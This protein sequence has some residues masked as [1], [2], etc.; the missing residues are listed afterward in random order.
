MM[1]N[2][3]SFLSIAFAA[4][5]LTAC[6]PKKP[7]M[8]PFD[9]AS[10]VG[11]EMEA[12]RGRL[13][14][15]QELPGASEADGR[16]QWRKDGYVLRADYRKRNG[17]V[18]GFFLGFDDPQKSI[19][20]ENKNEL[21]EAGHLKETDTRYNVEWTEDPDRVERFKSVQITPAPRRHKVLVRLTS[22]GLGATTLVEFSLGVVGNTGDNPTENGITLPPWH[23]ELEAQDGTQIKLQA[24]PRSS[25]F[26]VPNSA[27]VT[28]QIEVNGR[29][30]VKQTASAGGV[31]SCDW[32]V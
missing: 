17:R 19:K 32:E 9:V 4:L 8:P 5:C 2:A 30:V 28:V 11:F 13:G 31:A 6:G 27:Q 10:L 20:E 22:Q 1:F 12:V 16:R 23:R 26:A 15:G 25:R 14:A 7:D 21:L 24:A 3:R 18:T 29:V